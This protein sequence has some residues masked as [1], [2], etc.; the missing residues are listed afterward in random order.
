MEEIGFHRKYRP[1]T[2]TEYIGNER[3]KKSVFNAIRSEV[4]PQVILLKGPAGT[5]KTSMARLLAKEYLCENRDTE[6]GACNSCYFCQAMNDF[7]E[8]GRNDIIPNVREVDITDSNKK[9]DIDEILTEASSMSFDGNWRV[10]ILDECHMMTSSAQ[11]R[12]LKT[13]EEPPEKVLMILCTTNP[14]KLLDTIVSRC[15]FTFTV[16]KPTTK[17]LIELLVKVCKAEGLGFESSALKL[18]CSKS[19]GVPRKA[20][21][22]LENVAREVQDI[23]YAQVVEILSLVTEKIYFQFFGLLV[24][25]PINIQSYIQFLGSLK[26]S[27]DLALFMDGAISFMMKGLYTSNA[28]TL[29]S[30]DIAEIQQYKK[31]FTR[32]NVDDIAYLLGEL[33]TIKNSND[34][35][36]NLM[37]LGYRG[38]HKPNYQAVSYDSSVLD[39]TQH[40]AL[41]DKK[42]G[43]DAYNKS[44][45]ITEEEKQKSI[46]EFNKEVDFE[47]I[48]SMFGGNKILEE[49]T[50]EK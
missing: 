13:L 4:K 2:L 36:A 31:L 15:Q 33:I 26:E 27:Q 5:G 37:L 42:A 45:T 10:Y 1:K 29:D 40:N 17:E 25:E 34:I 14:E 28:V 19:D 7:I 48:C 8:S 18:I 3:L 32:F 24:E 21:I 46:E 9:Q 23:R 6:A 12:L 35:E 47:T 39:V 22:E 44:V 41:E 43:E 16:V 30:L 38:I 20:L 49:E 50:T 11:N